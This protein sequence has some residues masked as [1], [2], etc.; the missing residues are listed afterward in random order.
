METTDLTTTIL[1]NIRDDIEKLD[2]RLNAKIDSEIAAVRR[3]LQNCVTRDEFR[4]T[5]S[6][7]DERIDRIHARLI[8]NDL[9][10]TTAHQELQA[11][12]NQMMTYFGAHGSLE[13]RVDR[14]ER[15]I[16]DLKERV[17]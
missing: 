10:S 8:E 17:F 9:R 3:D 13:V 1:R 11:T 15:D 5:M 2:A 14:C 4:T 12:L 16:V 7:L 6:L